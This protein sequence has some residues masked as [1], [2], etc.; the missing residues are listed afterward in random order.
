M[1][2]CGKQLSS[3]KLPKNWKNQYQ[4]ISEVLENLNL[5]QNDMM[6]RNI[7]VFDNIINIIDFGLANMNNTK[8]SLRRLFI[9]LSQMEKNKIT[10]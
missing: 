6:C 9:I 3:E 8:S 4:E 2:Y 10:N 7:C 5:N 1:T